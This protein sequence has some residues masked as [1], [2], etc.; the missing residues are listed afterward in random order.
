MIPREGIAR[1]EEAR[2]AVTAGICWPDH[3][4][5]NVGGSVTGL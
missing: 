3:P 2:S 4:G 5:A 1:N